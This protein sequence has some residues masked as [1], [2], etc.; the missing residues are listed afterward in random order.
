MYKLSF[1]VFI[2]VT[3]VAL[4]ACTRRMAPFAPHRTNTDFHRAAQTNQTCL[5]CH[6]IRTIGKAH[7]TSDNCLRC[8][9]ILQGE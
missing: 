1:V 3:L 2:I 6:E 5:G 8:H 7:Q 9:R 4:P